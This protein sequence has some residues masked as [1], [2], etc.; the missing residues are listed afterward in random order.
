MTVVDVTGGVL[1]GCC[2]VSDT[3]QPLF[4]R[5][6]LSRLTPVGHD[7]NSMQKRLQESINGNLQKYKMYTYMYCMYDI[8]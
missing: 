7:G 1:G 4:P 5:V 3:S 8:L 6:E 2:Q